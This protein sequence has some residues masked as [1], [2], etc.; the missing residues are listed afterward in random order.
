MHINKN[1]HADRFYISY[2]LIFKFTIVIIQ[3][4][5]RVVLNGHA[6]E[7]FLLLVPLLLLLLSFFIY[8]FFNLPTPY[9]KIFI[10]LFLFKALPCYYYKS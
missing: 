10:F 7:P 1:L 9:K 5:I 6:K 3:C 4:E 2:I 8:L